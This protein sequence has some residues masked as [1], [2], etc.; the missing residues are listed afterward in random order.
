M[1]EKQEKTVPKLRTPKT[2]TFSKQNYKNP[3][4]WENVIFPD[5]CTMELHPKTR[6]LVRRP[7]RVE[8]QQRY[9]Q[10]TSKFGYK[11]VM[12]WGFIHFSGRRKIVK[13]EG[14]I[15]SDKY[16]Q[17]LRDHL[18][19]NMFFREIFQHD[20]APPHISQKTRD[21]VMASG[22]QLLE[23]LASPVA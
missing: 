19:D 16:I 12:F 22:I 8:Y 1:H 5:E 18:M 7:P 6:P 11:K 10:G 2:A 9:I 17:T 3:F 21:F 14:S 23:K 13:I 20:N 15:N 4:F